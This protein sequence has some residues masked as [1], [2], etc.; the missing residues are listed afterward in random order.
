MRP[1]RLS[2]VATLALGFGVAA[3]SL[4]LP[5][6]A[7]AHTRSR[8][9]S[10]WTVH[11]NELRM[12]FSVRAF[13]VTRLN[14]QA[15]NTPGLALAL[16]RHLEDSISVSDEEGDC[17]AAG[18]PRFVSAH[19]GYLR[20]EWSFSCR[21]GER[22]KINSEA[23][24]AVAPEHVHYARVRRDGSPPAEY[25]LTEL[26]RSLILSS[27]PEYDSAAASFRAYV[28]LGVRHIF[29]GADHVAFLLALLLLCRRVKEVL[30]MVTG[31]TLGHSVTLS[32]AALGF[33]RPNLSSIEAL[34]GFT[35]AL[36]GAEN[37][38]VKTESGRSFAM[39]GGLLMC[40]LALIK[41]CYGI[42][43]P[44]PVLLGLALFTLCFLPMSDSREHA[45]RFRPALTSVFGLVH[46][47]G[48]ARVLGEAGL[49]DRS[50]LPALLG[51]NI[52]VEIGQVLIV[53]AAATVALLLA[54]RMREY[55]RCLAFDTASALLCGLGLFWFVQ[56]SFGAY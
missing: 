22:I 50:L 5:R 11:G 2:L 56:R 16:E 42:G 23:F 40:A 21:G 25:L 46:G 14:T 31:F 43:L 30:L 54:S 44:T 27:S 39:S 15:A 24:F 51:F 47:F 20:V 45:A 38:A 10:S 36:V 7:A 33:L 28:V 35:V 34:I 1:C 32:L 8:S 41:L 53:G 26:Q 55:S 19:D 18:R 12:V 37:I 3:M 52:G 4:P 48:F 9:F 29:A 13:E 6:E 49:P 17:D